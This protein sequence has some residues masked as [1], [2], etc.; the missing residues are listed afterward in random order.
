MQWTVI[1]LFGVVGAVLG[2][3]GNVLVLRLPH[4]KPLGGRSH[5]DDCGK[6]LGFLDLIPVIGIALHGGKAHCCGAWIGFRYSLWELVSLLLFI[7]ASLVSPPVPAAFLALSLWLLLLIARIDAATQ[8]IPDILS[9]FLIFTAGIYDLLLRQWPIPG[10]VT[11]FAF[12][13]LQ[14]VLSRGRWIGTGDILLS[15]GAGL[16]V[17]TFTNA[18]LVLFLSYVV[19]ALWA[20]VLIYRK[21][22]GLNAHIAFGPF[23]CLATGIVV[24][25]G[26]RIIALVLP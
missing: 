11:L 3:F 15:L 22:A 12:F 1:V 5:C 4:G 7:A 8:T 10:V 21:K 16:L 24:L 20:L 26:H 25:A 14:W 2:S 17:A 13:G 23:L 6:Q 9:L 19:G 18:L